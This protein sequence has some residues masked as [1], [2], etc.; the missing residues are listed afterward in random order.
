MRELKLDLVPLEKVE[1]ETSPS[2][3]LTVQLIPT[4]PAIT[5]ERVAPVT[6]VKGPNVEQQA[7]EQDVQ[8]SQPIEGEPEV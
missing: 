1:T 8:L 4:T 5:S 6:F 7:E 3:T 2:P